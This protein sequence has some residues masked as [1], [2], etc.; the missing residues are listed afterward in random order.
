MK[1]IESADYKETGEANSSNISKEAAKRLSMGDNFYHKYSI[2]SLI[3]VRW[4]KF[5]LVVGSLIR[6]L[7]R[8]NG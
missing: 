4:R 8:I 6:K 7:L 2:N 1:D 5:V 3:Y